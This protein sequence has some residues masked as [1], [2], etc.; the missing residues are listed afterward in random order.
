MSPEQARGRPVDKRSDIWAFGCL[1]YEMLSGEKAFGGETV[2]DTLAAVLE[3][4]PNWRRLPVTTPPGVIRL[5]RRCLDKDLH[6]RLRDIGDAFLELEETVAR[7][8]PRVLPVSV[9][10]GVPRGRATAATLAVIALSALGAM[11]WATQAGGGA[12]QESVAPHFSQI[13]A[14]SGL[15]WFPSLSPD[16][17]WVAYGGD[18]NGTRHIFLQSTTGQTPID[19]TAD[20]TDGDDQPAFS[21]DGERIAFRS[22]REGGGIFVMG[23]T[24]EAVRRLTKRGFKPTW[25]PDAREIAFTLENADLDPQNTVG[26]SSLW[27][28]NVATGD[29]RQIGNVDAVLPNWS[30]NGH[31]IAY[32]TRG[33]ISGSTRLDIWTIDRSGTNP[34]AV[35]ADGASNW[36]PVWA[37][38]G[39]H[40]YFVSGRGGPINLWRVA[41]HEESGRTLGSP[42]P[43]TTP[44]AFATHIAISADGTRIAYSSILRTRN[45]QK[46]TIDPAT[47]MSS[48]EPTWITSGSRLWANPDPSPDGE[49]IAF[50]SSLQPE[51]DLYVARADGSGVRQL[52]TGVDAIDRMPRWSPDGTWLAFHSISGKDQHLWKIRA[53]GSGLQQLS[54]LADAIYPTWSPDGSRMAVLMAAGIG[55]AENN[56]Y[57]FDPNRP[58]TDQQPEVI[59]PPA[60]RPDEFV[61]NAWSPDGKQLAGQAGLAA[62]GIIVYSLASGRFEQV[63]D[64]GGYPVW[65]PDSRRVMF[66]SGG[67]DFF[68][69]DTRTKR[70]AKVFSVERDII[71]P[72]GLTRDGRQAF[73]SRRVTEGDIWLMTFDRPRETAS[74]R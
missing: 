30:P 41:I 25:S 39:R 42:Q 70:I 54:P 16:G 17:K 38:D 2:S 62:R 32:T 18:S 73:F 60:N 40:L 27:A 34:V 35:T 47:G 19:L 31:R 59:P 9:L 69:A 61:V 21:P 6:R 5:L 43:V 4:E 46:L 74:S 22:G 48:G 56:V 14:Q 26:L 50:Y 44:A 10:E 24:G 28:V 20:S 36:N 51:G 11:R 72:P 66:V 8:W 57:I 67:R 68:V 45:L 13:T 71:G 53:D 37:P 49:W 15:E 58:W 63:T 64:F 55:H 23:R 65:L 7:R 1:L 12:I 33:A 3:R 52:T 29:E